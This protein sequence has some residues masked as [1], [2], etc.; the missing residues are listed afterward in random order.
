LVT[1]GVGC[2][3]STNGGTKGGRPTERFCLMKLGVDPE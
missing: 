3:E 2:W 1:A